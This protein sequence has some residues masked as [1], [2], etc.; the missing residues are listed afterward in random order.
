MAT[1]K[2]IALIKTM[3]PTFCDLADRWYDDLPPELQIPRR[4]APRNDNSKSVA[5]AQ[6]ERHLPLDP[7]RQ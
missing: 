4:F 2:K 7:E 3:N 1:R 6:K 5:K